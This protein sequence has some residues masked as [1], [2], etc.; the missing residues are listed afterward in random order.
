MFLGAVSLLT[1]STLLISSLFGPPAGS[2]I[3]LT[4]A[5]RLSSLKTTTTECF[6]YLSTFT[7]PFASHVPKRRFF[8]DAGSGWSFTSI[9]SSQPFFA[10][11]FPMADRDISLLKDF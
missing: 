3:A 7:A 4:S 5:S 10:I 9:T 11:R 6:R 2:L 1:Q 8:L